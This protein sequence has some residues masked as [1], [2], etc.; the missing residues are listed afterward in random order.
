[1]YF[2]KFL[3]RLLNHI[4]FP[5]SFAEVL[6]GLAW[7]EGQ[8]V[9]RLIDVLKSLIPAVEASCMRQSLV[10]CHQRAQAALAQLHSV[11]KRFEMTDQLMVKI[12]FFLLYL[13]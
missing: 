1:M 8:V 12:Q 2:I 13:I 4:T 10:G 11:E 6:T 7:K 5:E 3:Y 9:A